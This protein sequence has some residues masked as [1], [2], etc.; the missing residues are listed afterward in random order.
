MCGVLA[1]EYQTLPETMRSD[2]IRFFDDN[3][4]WLVRVLKEGK[5]DGR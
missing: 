2:V 5:A 4:R 3:Q 1:A